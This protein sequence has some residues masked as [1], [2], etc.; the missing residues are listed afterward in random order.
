VFPPNE[1]VFS[2]V[3]EVKKF[4]EDYATSQ[5]ALRYPVVFIEVFSIQD[6][7]ELLD[8]LKKYSR[9]I[10]VVKFCK[11]CQ[12]DKVVFATSLSSVIREEFQKATKA[13]SPLTVYPLSEV[14]RFHTPILKALTEFQKTEPPFYP[15][16]VPLY[17]FSM[18]DLQ[19]LRM[20]SDNVESS[21]RIVIR[22]FREDSLKVVI[23]S[24]N[25]YWNKLP[26]VKLFGLSEYLSFFDNPTEGEV[27]FITRRSCK[28][29][30]FPAISSNR[31]ILKIV[32]PKVE[33]ETEEE[34]K[35]ILKEFQG[36]NSIERIVLRVLETWKYTFERVIEKWKEL[37]EERKSVILTYIRRKKKKSKFEKMFEKGEESFVNSL[38]DLPLKN[39]YSSP[40]ELKKRRYFLEK[41][42]I[43]FPNSFWKKVKEE[44]NKFLKLMLLTG[45]TEREKEEIIKT[46]K[47]FNVE[48]LDEALTYVEISFPALARYL[49]GKVEGV[50]QNFL[51]Y[52]YLYRICKLKGKLCKKLLE[53]KGKLSFADFPTRGQL[54]EESSCKRQVWIDGL[55]CEWLG[56]LSGFF[57]ERSYEVE[58]KVGRANLPTVTEENKPSETENLVKFFNE[59]DKVGHE[60]GDRIENLLKEL[61]VLE[62][63]LEQIEPLIEEGIVIT[64][65]HGFTH[66]S[67]NTKTFSLP[68]S[69][70][71]E[72]RGRAAKLK[73]KRTEGEHLI[74]EGDYALLKE[75]G[76]FEKA[77]G[78]G[79]EMHG[80]ALPEEVFVPVV[81]VYKEKPSTQSQV[82]FVNEDR[83]ELEEEEL[84]D[85]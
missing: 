19:N 56:V 39:P 41:L 83:K 63:I 17:R 6:W 40:E 46:L 75:H 27:Y 18:E 79:N 74:V 9:L 23:V 57:R 3:K 53:A 82:S 5:K 77:R 29:K 25:L 73:G 51:E 35:N 22:S 70:E 24:D 31:D 84:F 32:L 49:K 26:G 37:S 72:R 66:S 30:D 12:E 20:M 60:P 85:A 36:E 15:L 13:G 33:V 76:R 44:K 45:I 65:D 1:E 81:F 21:T 48:E 78:S 58:V 52:F 80:G 47:E 50:S 43:P 61:K 14:E 38:L 2:S 28:T 4:I 11:K 64:G 42:G 62:D 7:K 69:A 8:L 34:A 10:N 67:L 16:F 59:L 68:E 55:G 71:P 54:L